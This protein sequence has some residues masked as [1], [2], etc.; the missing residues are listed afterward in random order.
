MVEEFS[1]LKPR[2][3]EIV[4]PKQLPNSFAHTTLDATLQKLGRKDI[5]LVGFM[6]HM[7]IS[8]TARSG[9]DHGYRC[10]IVAN[11][12]ATRDL[13]D[14]FGGVVAADAVQKA[15]LAALRDRFATVVLT[16]TDILE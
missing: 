6:T 9:L 16:Q 11:A 10:T 1:S 14:G 4:I 15:E 3:G 2:E 7:C 13:P 8:A 5:I 12:C